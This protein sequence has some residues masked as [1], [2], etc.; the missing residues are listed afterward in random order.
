MQQYIITAY[1]GTD[2][3]ALARRMAAR[4]A[5]LTVAR[6]LKEKGQF[7]QGGAI[8]NEEGQMVGS[9]MMV[10]FPNP[11]ALD[12]WLTSDPY[13]VGDVWRRVEV[14]PFRCAQV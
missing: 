11:A 13:V 6:Q 4:E 10:A 2:A 1:D 12:A 14:K 3:E 9:V 8:L 7:I 5:H